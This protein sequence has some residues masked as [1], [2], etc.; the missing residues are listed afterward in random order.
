MNFFYQLKKMRRSEYEQRA[1]KYF[2]QDIAAALLP[3]SRLFNIIENLDAWHPVSADQQDF[4][5]KKG[6]SAL[7]E[8]AKSLSFFVKESMV[9]RAERYR[10]AGIYCQENE[11]KLQEEALQARLKREQEQ[12]A[13]E[14]EG[15][16]REEAERR[17]RE[18]EKAE[19]IAFKQVQEQKM[20]EEAERRAYFSILKANFPRIFEIDP[21]LE[22]EDRKAREQAE[23]KSK[24]AEAERIAFEN[25]P[26]RKLLEKYKIYNWRTSIHFDKLIDMLQRLDRGCRLPEVEFAWLETKGKEYES[27]PLKKLYH[28]NEAAFYAEEFKK[29]KDCWLA[30]NASSHYRKC[31]ESNTADALIRTIN[32]GLL[33]DSKLKSALCT[34]HGG[35]KRDLGYWREALSLGEQA[36]QL[37][38]KDFRPCTLLGAVNMEIGN[39]DLGRSWYDKAIERGYSEQAMD[40]ELRSIFM[41]AEKSR[42]DEMREYLLKLDPVRYSWAKKKISK[43]SAAAVLSPSIEALLKLAIADLI[44]RKD[45]KPRTAKAL[46]S[47]IH[48]RCGKNLPESEIDKVWDAL[49]RRGHVKI[50][51]EQ[52]SYAL[53]ASSS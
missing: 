51:G 27:K 6:L 50:N 26:V 31:D 7:A 10:A 44:K 48:A 17:R 20:K 22:E 45:K 5:R 12:A 14:E 52:V 30:V 23:E 40:D 18:K 41:R 9:E 38:P 1:E 34:T 29:K 24:R 39:Y 21:K 37:T 15:K 49:I 11:K 46:R 35:V 8:Y 25:D 36:H 53:P 19:R 43:N 42:Q 16:R 13:A 28:K 33:K 47:T 32:L 4:L 3:G 2:I